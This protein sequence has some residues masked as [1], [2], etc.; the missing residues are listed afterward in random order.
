MAAPIVSGIAALIWGEMPAGQT[1]RE[2]QERI[3]SSAQ[4]ITGTGSDWRYGRADACLAVTADPSAC[5]PQPPAA[6]PSIQP[7][8]VTPIVE[9]PVPAPSERAQPVPIEMP[10]TGES[11]LVPPRS[12]TPPPVPTWALSDAVAGLCA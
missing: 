10:A 7:P 4:P 8:P 12:P 1:N 11:T 2:V 6:T 3:F 9:Q 5:S